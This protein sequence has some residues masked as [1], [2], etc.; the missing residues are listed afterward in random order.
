MS[1]A[2]YTDRCNFIVSYFAH[3]FIRLCPMGYT[4]CCYCS[5]MWGINELNK[6]GK[7]KIV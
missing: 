7:N 5:T 4:K 2:M 3:Y 6:W 1:V